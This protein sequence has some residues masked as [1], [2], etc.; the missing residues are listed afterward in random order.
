MAGL[1][2]GM[3]PEDWNHA[4][5]TLVAALPSDAPSIAVIDEV[6][7]IVEQDAE[8]EGA[9]Q[10]VWDRELSARPVMLVLVGSD[11]SVM[12]ALT[13]YGRPFFGRA[14]KMTVRPLHLGDVAGNDR[15]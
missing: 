15:A 7:W 2:P 11:L 3:R 14:P 5:R 13:T 8:F 6:P 4:L 1:S 10:T 9:L 12:E